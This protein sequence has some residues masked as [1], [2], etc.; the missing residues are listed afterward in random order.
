MAS[1]FMVGLLLGAGFGAWVYSKTM[2]STGNNT[3]NSLILAACAGVG[4]L[5]LIMVLL[6]IFFKSN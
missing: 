4:A 6:G 3:K 2:R 5:V 1:N